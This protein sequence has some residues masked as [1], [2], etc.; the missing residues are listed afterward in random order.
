MS[1]IVR[2]QS[3]AIRNPDLKLLQQAASIVA[4]Q[5]EGG[6]IRDYYLT[7]GG[8]R[9]ANRRTPSTHLGIFT[10]ALHHGVGLS[11]DRQTRALLFV[12]D[13]WGAEDEWE[14]LTAQ[15]Q[16]TYIGLVAAFAFQQMGWTAEIQEGVEEGELVVVGTGAAYA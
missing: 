1:H 14:K 2:A 8:Y 6:E 15:V 11:L 3:T 10:H 13:P 5:F 12:G 16:Q 4:R 7:Y 9:R